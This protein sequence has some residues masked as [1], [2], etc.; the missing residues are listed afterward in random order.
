MELHLILWYKTQGKENS[1]LQVTE[2]SD[3]VSFS[4]IMKRNLSYSQLIPS[5]Q[6]TLASSVNS[7]IAFLLCTFSKTSIRYTGTYLLLQSS[8]TMQRK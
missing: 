2:K 4:H 5:S 6:N 8:Q 1:K 7:L 3:T